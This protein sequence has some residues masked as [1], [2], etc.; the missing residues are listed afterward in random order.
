MAK[1]KTEKPSLVEMLARAG[2]GYARSMKG[3]MQFCRAY[4]DTMALYPAEYRKAFRDKWTLY[5]DADWETFEEIGRGN[6]LPQFAFCSGS[7]KRGIMRLPD[8]LGKQMLLA[9][10]LKDG[11]VE[12]V[13]AK[14]KVV[15]KSLEE[16]SKLEEDSILFAMKEGG[17]PEEIRKFAYEFRK[18][19]AL[20]NGQKPAVEIVGDFLVVHRKTKFSK[21]EVQQWL[22][23]MP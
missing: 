20:K 16:L 14:G 9:G 17:S 13:S 5:T 4:V 3:L 18:E 22:A 19:F 21:K 1:K 11:K 6:L 8:S 23:K 10:F 7:M 15:L 12:T 2:R